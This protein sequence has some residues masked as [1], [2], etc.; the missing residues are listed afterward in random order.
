LLDTTVRL[1]AAFADTSDHSI[2][3]IAATL[4]RKRLVGPDDQ[5]P[6]PVSVFTDIDNTNP[7]I[8]PPKVPACMFWVDSS[9]EIELKSG[10]Y[11]VA[12]AVTV[13]MAYITDEGVSEKRALSDTGY[14]LRAAQICFKRYNSQALSAGY[15]E[16][17]DIKIHQIQ[18][19]T[20][21]RVTEAVGR[22]KMWGFLG[23]PVIVVDSAT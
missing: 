19:I 2:N 23:I 11:S 18:K 16:L 5:A 21:Q 1:L 12:R 22:R 17:N 15:R 7:G 20:E 9:A 3:K 10:L 6:L 13:A 8:D 14:V 4:K